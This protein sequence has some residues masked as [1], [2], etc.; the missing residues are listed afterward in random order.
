[1]FAKR[2]LLGHLFADKV[3]TKNANWHIVGIIND[4]YNNIFQQIATEST[5]SVAK[6]SLQRRQMFEGTTVSFNARA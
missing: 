5:P 1:M 3:T 2:W 4:N 6:E